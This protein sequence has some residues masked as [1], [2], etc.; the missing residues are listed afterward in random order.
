MAA[1]PAS[2]MNASCSAMH[3]SISGLRPADVRAKGR[4][5]AKQR[6][7]VCGLPLFV[8]VF[9]AVGGVEVTLLSSDGARVDAGTVV[10]TLD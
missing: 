4:L 8:Q 6:L 5:L 9:H 3:R 7:V 10:A 2:P 1:M